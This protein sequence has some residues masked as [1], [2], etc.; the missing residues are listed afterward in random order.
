MKKY[1]SVIDITKLS[2]KQEN[3]IET[4]Y[5]NAPGVWIL[6]GKEQDNTPLVCLQVGQSKNIGGEIDRDIS[7]LNDEPLEPTSK[8]YVNQF[9]KR[10]F[11]YEEYPNRTKI[12]Y[13]KIAEKY[14]YFI[15]VCI[16]QGEGLKHDSLR[17]DIEKYIAYKT[18]CLYWVN[19]GQYKK[20]KNEQEIELIKRACKEECAALFENIKRDY[21]NADILNK[22]LDELTAGKIDLS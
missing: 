14:N 3:N 13:N 5:K 1:I 22:F 11:S 6:L 21:E 15:F 16:A 8:E 19:G 17:K 4:P 2:G 20:E 9:G 12:L 7:Y 18:S 10:M